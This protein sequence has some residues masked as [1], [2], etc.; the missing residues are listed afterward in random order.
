MLVCGVAGGAGG[1]G[2]AGDIT[3][4]GDVTVPGNSDGG[5]DISGPF[6]CEGAVGDV[7]GD[8]EVDEAGGEDLVGDD[9]SL[10]WMV[11]PLML[12]LVRVV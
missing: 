1:D 2:A 8:G 4:G 10:H 9:A 7:L 6:V 11:V 3:G 12:L 5:F